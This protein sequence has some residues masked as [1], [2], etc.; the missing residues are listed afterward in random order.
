MSGRL[1]AC[2]V[3]S[4]AIPKLVVGPLG[5]ND[6]G[7]HKLSNEIRENKNLSVHIQYIYIYMYISNYMKIIKVV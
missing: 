6:L 2:A 5:E 4:C 3:S 7:V 1:I